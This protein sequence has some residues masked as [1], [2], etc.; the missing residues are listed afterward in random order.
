MSEKSIN[1]NASRLLKYSK[2]ISRLNELKNNLQKKFEYTVEQSFTKL[3]NV[4]TLTLNADKP[5][6]GNY[7]KAEDLIQKIT[8]LQKQVLMGDKD[9]PISISSQIV[10]NFVKIDDKKGDS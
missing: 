9:N 1:E 7:L 6:F 2:V 5:D 8:G 10:H 3:E 4:Q